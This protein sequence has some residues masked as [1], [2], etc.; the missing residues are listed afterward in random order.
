MARARKQPLDL[1]RLANTAFHVLTRLFPFHFAAWNVAFV[2]MSEMVNATGE[3]QARFMK[4]RR[5]SM[6]SQLSGVGLM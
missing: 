6:L 4:L 5:E 3:E 2:S 1:E